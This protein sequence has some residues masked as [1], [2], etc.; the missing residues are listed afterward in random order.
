MRRATEQEV[1]QDCLA[2]EVNGEAED[3]AGTKLKKSFNMP[4]FC[5]YY[6][7]LSTKEKEFYKVNISPVVTQRALHTPNTT[8]S[9]LNEHCHQVENCISKG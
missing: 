3:K 4:N 6:F 9:V 2:E 7:F 5:D 8:T 1:A